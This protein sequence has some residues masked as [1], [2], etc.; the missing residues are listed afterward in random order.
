MES[1][2]KHCHSLEVGGHFGATKIVAKVLQSSFYWPSLFKDAFAFVAAC[3]QCQR[4]GNISQK[5][6]MPLNNILVVEL[7]DV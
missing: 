3:D 7:F 6:E 4:S 2:L 1:I 5:N